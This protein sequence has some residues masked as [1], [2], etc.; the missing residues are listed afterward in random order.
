MTHE[1]LSFPFEPDKTVID[2]RFLVK[3]EL[4]Q[5][6]MGR[7]YRVW[8]ASVER[9]C[10]LKMLAPKLHPRFVPQH[11]A[12]LLLEN[13]AKTLGLLAEGNDSF[14]QV[15][16]RG[17]VFVAVRLEGEPIELDLPY[18]VMEFLH[19]H[20]FE[21]LIASF[22]SRSEFLPWVVVLGLAAQ[23][24]RAL[25]IAHDRGVVHRDI[26]PDNIFLQQRIHRL[27]CVKF[28]DFGVSTREGAKG[29]FGTGTTRYGAPEL[30]S[31]RA[32]RESTQSDIYPLG[33]VIYELA[34]LRGPFMAA[35]KRDFVQAHVYQDAPRLSQFR[36]DAPAG[37]TELLAAALSKN[38]DARPTAS[39]FADA[40][41]AVLAGTEGGT[42]ADAQISAL[43]TTLGQRARQGAAAAR[44]RAASSGRGAAATTQPGARSSGLASARSEVFVAR[45]PIVG[46]TAAPPVP[47][48]RS[49]VPS[50]AASARAVAADTV[51]D[52]PLPLRGVE[53]GAA[54]S[55]PP[56]VAKA[57]VVLLSDTVP[58]APP[59]VEGSPP[60]GVQLE[61]VE[62][63][64]ILRS[65]AEV[66]DAIWEDDTHYMPS[67]FQMDLP[68]A[69]PVD[70]S[71]ASAAKED[72]ALSRSDTPVV[73]SG[74]RSAR[75]PP[76]TRAEQQGPRRHR[77]ENVSR[78][79]AGAT[80]VVMGG[81]GVGVIWA[82]A[83]TA[84][85]LPPAAAEIAAPPIGPE[86]AAPTEVSARS[87]A[88]DTASRPE[89]AATAASGREER[90]GK[91]EAGDAAAARGLGSS[92]ATASPSPPRR[93]K[94]PGDAKSSSP[95][96][97]RHLDGRARPDGDGLVDEVRDPIWKG[98]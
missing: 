15:F 24:A 33:L 69:E 38:P 40:L 4:G 10:V 76:A 11:D 30:L 64:P 52:A 41:D 68:A 63:V 89:A 35:S 57:P 97:S 62:H 1:V 91:P 59:R 65:M 60:A 48:I 6:G 22:R 36:L 23:A 3:G 44:A 87:E 21:A 26:K 46:E 73:F 82:T 67:P 16:D 83:R 51:P 56:H 50:G 31:L 27:P 98:Y 96:V 28:I 66:Y 42:G 13:E 47:A 85:S 18:Y 79:L 14:V 80:L 78:L 90:G 45:T 29:V 61:D 75:R 39:E 81:I 32:D 77:P 92:A 74:A 71:A 12:R 54:R 9:V 8:Q 86:A 49:A 2:G 95:A 94:A 37:L 19:G 53:S 7:C 17:Q 55:F 84:P 43:L 72:Q 58:D 34:A 88:V 25:S 70:G 5:G 20:S 93:R